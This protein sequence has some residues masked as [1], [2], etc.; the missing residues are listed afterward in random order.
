MIEL[1]DVEDGTA[2]LLERLRGLIQRYVVVTE[3][4]QERMALPSGTRTPFR[5]WT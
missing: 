3:P 2:V 4:Q 5:A 1:D